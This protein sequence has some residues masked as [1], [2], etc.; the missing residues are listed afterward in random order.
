M[1]EAA[2]G[3]GHAAAPAKKRRRAPQDGN[4][5]SADADRLQARRRRADRVLTQAAAAVRADALSR[6]KQTQ[7]V[8]A[9]PAGRAITLQE[10]QSDVIVALAERTWGPSAPENAPFDP[11]VVDRL[12]S[13]ELTG[14]RGSER[15][16]RA[17]VLELS[18][19]LERYLWPHFDG[20]AASD[21]HVMSIVLLVNEKFRDGVPAWDAFAPENSTAT[22]DKWRAFV[23][24]VLA[25]A[26]GGLAVAGR[27]MAPL[28]AEQ[29]LRFVI[30]L[31]Q[32]LEAPHVRDAVLPLAS[33]P[34]W[35]ALHARRREV[36]LL[37]DAKLAK[38]WRAMGRREAK[39]AAATKA[40]V[41]TLV[42][43]ACTAEV[44]RV[45]VS[46]CW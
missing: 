46:C 16:R 45:L 19:Y 24:R 40:E 12:Y 20:A 34:L 27:P 3:A 11:E 25:L 8:T 33:I 32:S 1:D 37:A 26:A 43:P 38:K 7:M 9:Q 44:Y 36:E 29:Y 10:L 31:F 4:P 39:E 5:P 30:H 42:T 22:T 14:R 2:G 35:H 13:R 6:S 21:A 23:A 17:Q 28:E 41:R 15:A 18:Q